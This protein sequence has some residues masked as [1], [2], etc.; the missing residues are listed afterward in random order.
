MAS[1]LEM[2]KMKLRLLELEEE[3]ERE[4]QQTYSSPE[5]A[6]SASVP[7]ADIFDKIYGSKAYSALQGVADLPLGAA[8]L[9]ANVT[10]IGDEG[11]NEFMRNREQLMQ[12]GRDATGREGFDFMRLG[13]NVAGGGIAGKGINMGTGLVQ[14]SLRGMGTGAGFGAIAPVAGE[15]E[16]FWD[17]KASQ[18]AG[19]AGFGALAPG[20]IS[21]LKGSGNLLKSSYGYLD[22]MIS[23]YV[24]AH[25]GKMSE[26]S[27]KAIREIVG[28]ERWPAVRAMLEGNKNP[29]AQGT[30][31]EVAAPAKSTGLS[32]LQRAA[33]LGDDYHGQRS[34]QHVARDQALKSI[35]GSSDDR[36]VADMERD[37]VTSV[38]RNQALDSA[39]GNTSKILQL[40]DDIARLEG[41]TTGARG[42]QPNPNSQ[43]I[44]QPNPITGANNTQV[45]SVADAVRHRAGIEDDIGKA[46]AGSKNVSNPVGLKTPSRYAPHQ[47][48]IEK[49]GAALD[50]AKVIEA[51]KKAELELIKFQ[52]DA[53]TKHGVE[54]ST[55][56]P[57]IKGIDERIAAMEGNP[58]VQKILKVTRDELGAMVR[59]DGTVNPRSLYEYRKTGL[60]ETLEGL[61]KKVDNSVSA[62]T[63]KNITAVKGMLDDVIESASGG[64][65]K[66]YLKAYESL[67]R[68][69]DRMELGAILRGGL[70]RNKGG[71]A[72]GV[73][74]AFEANL[75]G[76][77]DKLGKETGF[78]Q[79]HMAKVLG[80]DDMSNLGRVRSDVARSAQ[81]EDLATEGV[82][83][84]NVELGKLP[85]ALIREIMV[86]NNI[87]SRAGVNIQKDVADDIS[88]LLMADPQKGF[89][90]MIQAV[91]SAAPK[92]APVVVQSILKNSPQFSTMLSGVT[93][94]GATQAGA[95]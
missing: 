44:G 14:Q 31:G 25:T 4:Q 33:S 30:A 72:Q 68:P 63:V 38:L 37:K 59:K 62:S 43:G 79:R 93:A 49:A 73:A 71:E 50:D 6:Q 77:M 55:A 23:P 20:A 64:G 78:A 29:L 94:A 90:A 18:T 28:E 74:E 1:Q 26:L 88:R 82:G 66:R 57:I 42:H 46:V 51:G 21:L 16:D 40:D 60:D 45:T 56:N 34:A 19:G 5:P 2:N 92:E 12:E 69:H 3:E 58:S 85:N 36:V 70:K 84:I 41:V 9:A 95:N 80:G 53:T 91:E 61:S 7:E 39:E 47:N 15:D 67:S 54:P 10:G 87:L 52:R 76:S 11:M 24:K 22:D 17:T 89:A 83:T 48:Y 81:M 86:M 75:K 35:S 27:G 65:W 13:G 8:Q 32:A